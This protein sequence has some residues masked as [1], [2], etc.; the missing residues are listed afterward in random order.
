[1]LW[2]YLC[3]YI[4]YWDSPSQYPEAH[5]IHFQAVH[6]NYR[7]T[8]AGAIRQESLACVG[9]RYFERIVR[10]KRRRCHFD[11]ATTD[12]CNSCARKDKYYWFIF[13]MSLE[14]LLQ[15]QLQATSTSTVFTASTIKLSPFTCLTCLAQEVSF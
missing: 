10:V 1:M 7:F 11:F 8:T 12:G 15:S 13:R 6:E 9:Q 4:I 14:A 3:K 5:E 2:C